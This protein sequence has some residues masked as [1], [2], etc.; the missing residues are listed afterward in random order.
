VN[1]AIVSC[2]I[3]DEIKA[4]QVNGPLPS[5]LKEAEQQLGQYFQGKRKAFHL[6]LAPKGTDFQQAVWQKLQEIPH[7]QF[8]TYGKI[9]AQLG[10]VKKVRAV[11]A[12]IAKN[13]IAILIP[14]HRVVGA[15]G[16]MTGF[17]WGI[18]RKKALLKL[19]KASIVLP[20]LF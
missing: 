3:V 13:P 15:R 14:C 2:I 8:S 16:E 11:A 1:K 19:E 5:I 4:Q 9:A 6:P 20:S 7:G 12:A 18:E 10:D 17:A